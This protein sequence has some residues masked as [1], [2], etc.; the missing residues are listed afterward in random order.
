MLFVM[1]HWV[2]RAVVSRAL[3]SKLR[4]ETR[5]YAEKHL[6]ILSGRILYM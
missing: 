4:E 2:F 1:Q 3:C 5:K 6:R